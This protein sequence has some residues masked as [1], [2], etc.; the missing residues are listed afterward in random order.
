MGRRKFKSGMLELGTI[1]WWAVLRLGSAQALCLIG[2]KLGRA[3]AVS[4]YVVSKVQ[5]LR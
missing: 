1:F 3:Q 4:G 5:T 2:L